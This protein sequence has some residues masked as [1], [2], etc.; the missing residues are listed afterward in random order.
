MTFLYLVSGG[1]I[2]SE[3]TPRELR[4]LHPHLELIRT[5]RTIQEARRYSEKMKFP[6]IQDIK[7]SWTGITPEGREMMREKKRGA[8]NPNHGGLSQE[9]KMKISRNKRER[10]RGEGNP[11]Y[12][13]RHRSLSKMKTSWSLRKL[14]KRRWC[15]DPLG[16]EHLV[17]YSFQLP[18]GWAWG[19]ARNITRRL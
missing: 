5:F 14:P 16:T 15:V 1:Y 17:F 19:R 12:N 10:Y 4:K 13:R 18:V 2:I 7:K 11:M 6:V 8:Q 3:K 9:H